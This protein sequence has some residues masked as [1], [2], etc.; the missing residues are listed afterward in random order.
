MMLVKVTVPTGVPDLDTVFALGGDVTPPT[1][2]PDNTK[3]TILMGLNEN[4]Q[5]RAIKD[6]VMTQEK[7]ALVVVGGGQS[8]G[9]S[10]CFTPESDSVKQAGGG[11]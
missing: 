6:F 3:T 7:A 8:E 4:L 5:K 10:F 9:A 1:T 11:W 2:D